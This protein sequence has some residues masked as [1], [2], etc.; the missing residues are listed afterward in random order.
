MRN[1]ERITNIKYYGNY[2]LMC[3]GIVV[4]RA[5]QEVIQVIDRKRAEQ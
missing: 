5:I 1:Y 3:K 4:S 2:A